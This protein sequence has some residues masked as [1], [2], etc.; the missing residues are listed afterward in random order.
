MVRNL[1]LLVPLLVIRVNLV[2]SHLGKLVSG[3]VEFLE[4]VEGIAVSVNEV[5]PF[6]MGGGSSSHMPFVTPDF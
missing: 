5:S 3:F 1:F 4:A 2:A 6:G